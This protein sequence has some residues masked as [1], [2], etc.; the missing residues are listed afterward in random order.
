ME[1]I[2]DPEIT[3]HLNTVETEAVDITLKQSNLSIF[4]P[5][6]F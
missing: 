4:N 1:T 6:H 5:Y 3:I 2:S